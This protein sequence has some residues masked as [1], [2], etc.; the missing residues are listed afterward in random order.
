VFA[1]T[2]SNLQTATTGTCVGLMQANVTDC[3]ISCTIVLEST[4]L[5]VDSDY[6]CVLMVVI[7]DVNLTGWRLPASAREKYMNDDSII[8]S[9]G[10]SG[11]EGERI[12]EQLDSR[13][14]RAKLTRKPAVQDELM[15]GEKTAEEPIAEDVYND[16]LL[17]FGI[18]I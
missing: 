11:K 16:A 10:I 1:A 15:T 4:L 14:R 7:A 12:S 3:G 5:H 2:Y 8:K 17:R 18:K 13:T 9:G 6:Y